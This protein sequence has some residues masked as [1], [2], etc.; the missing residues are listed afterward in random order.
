M[1]GEIM[2]ALRAAKGAINVEAVLGLGG[3]QK[4]IEALALETLNTE[5]H[6]KGVAVDNFGELNINVNDEDMKKLKELTEKASL[7]RM[8]GG[9][10]KYAAGTALMNLGETTGGEGG[11]GMDFSTLLMLNMMTGGKGLA[12]TL[13]LTEPA[14]AAPAGEA[15]PAAAAAPSVS[16]CYSCNG[17]ADKFCASC[18]TNQNCTNCQARL[19]GKYCASCGT[20]AA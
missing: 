10:D 1:A 15:Q 2:S 20:P 7:I 12:G 5:L 11:S 3:H 16:T 18:G 8:A 4:A 6:E 17:P 14:P 9:Y 13:G 19:H